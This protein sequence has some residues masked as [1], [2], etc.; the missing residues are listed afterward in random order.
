MTAV[1]LWKEYRQ[2]RPVWLAIALLSVLLAVSVGG[3]LGKGSGLEVFQEERVSRTLL[4]AV[5]CLAVSFGTVSGALLLAGEK[6]DGTQ[7]FLDRLAGWREVLWPRKFLAGVVLTLAQALAL[8]ALALGLGFGPWETA[9]LLPLLGLDALAWGLL[10]GAVCG[11]VLSAVLIGIAFMAAS[12][13]FVLP[14][15]GGPAFAAVKLAAAA[16]AGYASWRLFTEPDRLRRQAA[17]TV[18]TTRP[19]IR[20]FPA[21]RVLVWLAF[22]QGRWVLAA[23]SV[24]ALALAFTVHLSPL[25][26]WPLGSLALGL[27]CGLSVFIPDQREG[28]RFLGAQR[29][30]PGRVWGV[31]LLFWGAVL[32][33]LVGLA[34]YLDVF[35]GVIFFP[36]DRLPASELRGYRWYDELGE[37]AKLVSP[38]VFF[39]LWPLYGFCFAQ[40]VGLV[41]PRPFLSVTLALGLAPAVVAVWVPSLLA[42]GL[43]L[44][45]LLVVPALLLLVTRLA[46]WPCVSGRLLTFRPLLG[47]GAG[48]L[49]M[50]STVAGCLWY[51]A[52]EV[53]D[54]GEPFDVAAFRAEL[55]PPEKNEAGA[56][57]RKAC[58][59]LLAHQAIVD[60]EFPPPEVPMRLQPDAAGPASPFPDSY[61]Q[62]AGKVVET[63]WPAQGRELGRWLDRM[64]E[65]E[66]AAEARHAAGLPLGVV[67]D[68]RLRTGSRYDSNIQLGFEGIA[69]LL[70]ARAVQLQARGDS[71]AALD[72]LESVLALSRQVKNHAPWEGLM[73]G[74]SMERIA[75]SGVRLWLEKL[76]PDRELLRAA[77]EVLRQHESQLPPATDVIKADFLVYHNSDHPPTGE[78]P[79]VR[80]LLGVARQAPWEKERQRRLENAIVAGLLREAG[81]PLSEP[82]HHSAPDAEDSNSDAGLTL[83]LGLPPDEGPGSRLSAA[84]WWELVRQSEMLSETGFSFARLVA[85]ARRSVRVTLLVAAAACY[86][87]DHGR[88]PESLGALVPD[89]LAVVPGDPSTGRP[90]PYHISKGEKINLPGQPP[91]RILPGQAVVGVEK[92]TRV[93]LVPVWPR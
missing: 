72:H 85:S 58:N 49:L 64:F 54:L 71:R 21:A 47:V 28:H 89:Y 36:A 39:G 92:D 84:R 3:T 91:V 9:A 53:P 11:R 35:G 41:A 76:G 16:A 1:L 38:A 77:V 12:W 25:V 8:S 93:Y 66:W 34:W 59:D 10:G 61:R 80:E 40:F 45:Q 50:L 90:F 51:R 81:R 7:V 67:V 13:V 2:Q 29:F 56:L 82:R 20:L 86:Q 22:R 60:K 30:P 6:D 18:S 43:P 24:I 4:L 73:D 19:P 44:W 48:S 26:L 46:L 37:R 14:L 88:P 15:G 42:G 31:K 75:L 5:Q 74:H 17:R 68:P 69:I 87:A 27:L 52:A 63:G 83:Q 65:G 57:V 62:L 33:A 70:T 23:A 79:L 55:P 32:F 78:T